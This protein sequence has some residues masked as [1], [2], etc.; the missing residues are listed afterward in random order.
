MLPYSPVSSLRILTLAVAAGLLF[1]A[2]P[3]FGAEP[4]S[5]ALSRFDIAVTKSSRSLFNRQGDQRTVPLLAQLRQ[6]IDAGQWK[7]AIARVHWIGYQNQTDDVLNI[8]GEVIA[9][10]EVKAKEAE[11]TEIHAIEA[12]VT[13]AGGACLQASNARELD[14]TVAELRSLG[15]YRRQ[16][17]SY[18]SPALFVAHKKLASAL[19]YLQVWQDYLALRSTGKE[20]EAARKMEEL[21]RRDEWYA[22]VPRSEVLQRTVPPPSPP[23]PPGPAVDETLKNILAKMKSLDDL[24]ATTADVQ[25]LAEKQPVS[26]KLRATLETMTRLQGA[27]RA[28]AAQDY[29]AAFRLCNEQ[30]TQYIDVAEQLTPLRHQLVLEVL[31]HYLPKRDLAPPMPQETV[32][33][34]LMRTAKSAL[35][36]QDWMLALSSFEA[37]GT[38]SFGQRFLPSWLTADVSAL[39]SLVQGDKENAAGQFARAA[40]SYQA[41]LEATSENAPVP[42]IAERLRGLRKS[43]PEAFTTSA[44][45]TPQTAIR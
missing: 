6:E 18:Q 19:A 39:R 20:I 40:A 43:H 21:A 3:L 23:P 30:S 34:Y 37:L 9:Q 35:A 14:Q 10:I 36:A 17:E 31:P 5:E 11:E 44:T 29:A 15:A 1:C 16:S 28:L 7:D 12:A 2:G 27:R 8:G 41:A 13:R 25:A 24:D 33:N 32:T 4:L 45:R 26:T 42:V 38:I 22:A